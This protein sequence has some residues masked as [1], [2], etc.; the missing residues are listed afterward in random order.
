MS[1]PGSSWQQGYAYGKAVGIDFQLCLRPDVGVDVVSV[2]L[3]DRRHSIAVG[4]VFRLTAT[5][6]AV[7]SADKSRNAT[8]QSYADGNAVG[9]PLPRG[10]PWYSWWQ[11]YAYSKAVGIDESMPTALP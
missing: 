2:V 11:G 5:D 1:S 6:G 9:I 3:S 10:N 7:K 8:S 4:S